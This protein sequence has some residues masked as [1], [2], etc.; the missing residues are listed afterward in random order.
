MGKNYKKVKSGDR[1]GRLVV[2]EAVGK[3]KNGSFIWKCRCDCGKYKEVISSSLN[4]KLTRSCG[5]LY[6]EIKGK[7]SI[8]HGMIDSREYNTWSSMKQRCYYTRHQY[9]DR[10]GGRGIVVCDRWLESFENFYEDMGKCPKGMTLDRINN[11]GNYE[12][13]NCKW[14]TQTEQS[15]NTG[16]SSANK[17]GYKGVTYHKATGKW[18]AI[19]GING[20]TKHLGVYEDIADAVKA[21]SDAEKEYWND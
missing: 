1:V 12:P 15:R 17:S 4:S 19:I 13:S 9:Y 10:Y 7:Q 21:R 18:I 11:D 14:S 6:D 2:L 8:T 3:S 5:C 20:K 16:I